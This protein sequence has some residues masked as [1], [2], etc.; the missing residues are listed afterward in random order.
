VIK[1]AYD[2]PFFHYFRPVDGVFMC[3]F[4]SLS[5]VNNPHHQ[6]VNP[7]DIIHSIFNSKVSIESK[8]ERKLLKRAC[9]NVGSVG[10][11]IIDP[12]LPAW[13]HREISFNRQDRWATIPELGHFP[14]ILNP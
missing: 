7:T 8:Q 4:Y 5:T 3:G 13:S 6:Y 14:L 9:L 10:D 2:M 11:L 1:D 12:K